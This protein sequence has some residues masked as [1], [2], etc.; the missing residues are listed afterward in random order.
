MVIRTILLTLFLVSC[1]TTIDSDRR[2]MLIRECEKRFTS[3][4]LRWECVKGVVL[5]ENSKGY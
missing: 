3:D 5:D 2:T 1:N 4:H